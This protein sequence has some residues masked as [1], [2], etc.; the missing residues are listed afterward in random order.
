MISGEV[1]GVEM[2]G[3]CVVGEY[4]IGIVART[5]SRFVWECVCPSGESLHQAK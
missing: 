2:D 3:E 4:G 5:S 1:A